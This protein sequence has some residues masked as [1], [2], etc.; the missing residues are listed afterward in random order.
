[1]K[2]HTGWFRTM[3]MGAALVLLTPGTLASADPDDNANP[4]DSATAPG[5]T[6]RVA[7]KWF[8]ELGAAPT[9]VGG[10]RRTV[11]VSQDK[12]ISD[13][14][15]E[16][17]PAQVS[18]NYTSLFNGFAVEASPEM[19]AT[20]AT[21]PGVK[22]VY[23]VVPVA[24]PE[25]QAVSPEL[26]SALAMTGADVVQSQLGFTGQGIKVGIIDTGIDYDHPDFGGSGTDGT[27]PWPTTRVAYG[28]DFVGDDYNAD[29]TSPDFDPVPKPD[30]QPDDCNGHGTHVAGIVG[31][32]GLLTGVA[33]GATLGAYRIFGC[34]GASD[35][36]VVLAAMEK[37]EAD[38]MDVVNMSLGAAY[39]SWGSYPTST[40]ADRLVRN[41]VVVVAS[42][43][44][45]GSFFTQSVGSPSAASTAISVASYDNT[46]V[47]LEE[48][49][50]R[51][52]ADEVS[53]G[54][55]QASGAP[56]PTAALDGTQIMHTTDPI[57]CTA[58]TADLT[59][60]VAITQRGTCPFAEK[61]VYAQNAG[62]KALIIYNN[63][64]GFIAPSVSGATPI[65]IPVVGIRQSDG[66]LIKQSL[67]DD[68]DIPTVAFTGNLTTLPNPTAGLISGFSSWGL[69]ADLTLK[70]DL[71][72][73]G[74]DI[75]STYPLE[76][77]GYAT[78]SGTSMAAPHVAGAVA[79]MLQANPGL[80]PARVLSNL[81]NTAEPSLYS[82]NPALGVLDGAHHQ[83]AGLIQV[84]KA[85]LGTSSVSPGKIS[86]GESADGPHTETLTL[87][88]NGIDEVTWNLGVEDAVSTHVDPAD[89][90]A[91]QSDV[92]FTFGAATV[93]F[94]AASVTIPAGGTTTV[95]VTISPDDDA[96]EG[97][98][99]SGFIQ[100]E[101]TDGE[102]ISVPFAGMAG[103]YGALP[104]LP[105]LDSGLP[106]LVVLNQCRFWEDY[107]CID[108]DADFEDAD[109]STVYQLG[110]DLPSVYAVVAY[111][112]ARLSM[113]VL[114]V[115]AAGTPIESSKKTAY[116]INGV[117]RD[118]TDSLWLWDGR[119]PTSSGLFQEVAPGNYMLRLTALAA[120]GD[121]G[122]QSW[123]SPAFGIKNS[124]V[125]SPSPT[126]TVT[127]TAPGPQPSPTVTVTLP[128]T[129]LNDLYSTPGY[130]DVNGRKWFTACEK[131]SQTTRCRTSIFGTQVTQ[132]NGK[133]VAR[134]GWVFN[135]LTYLPSPRALW[136]DNP[137]GNTGEYTINGRQWRTECDTPVSGRNGC[138]SYIRS[139]V[140]QV[141]PKGSG[142]N[143]EWKTVWVFNNIVRF[144]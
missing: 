144:S 63:A 77:D 65:T 8:V 38:G 103:D 109:A 31:A 122:T 67:T 13:A 118:E 47:R 60:K 54:F 133:F 36:A 6:N 128:P 10:S 81:Q 100:L 56:A 24:I 126:P 74:G 139:R 141:A 66:E 79:L 22:A 34:D 107:R 82:K 59:G 29:S 95:D 117:G 26:Y 44:N 102:V 130:H 69:A 111:P 11:K 25:S 52:G 57:G 2:R 84:D 87:V 119:L 3:A 1:M 112:A 43:G 89:P 105:D 80:T 75:Y 138:R 124:P 15:A 73:P 61:A 104:I 94:S 134:N 93:Q 50:V 39:E 96:V 70:P 72:A 136:K 20:Y 135:N 4:T 12:F 127:V 88:N 58:E 91:T 46:K 123:T 28:Y 125:P 32:G 78:L 17:L 86:T 55:S 9:S 97:T 113:E 64:T 27:T 14:R 85:I 110:D 7:G 40:A 137:L 132:E 68:A 30:A 83:G 18:R 131:Y 140:I 143:Y 114:Q 45:N 71:G 53:V 142:Y 116:A 121:G 19:A 5:P 92:K 106:A 16:G 48:M 41:G 115:S 62:A 21:I 42:A 35:T 98:Q 129:P 37:A 120:D 90:T 33:P 51:D 108:E 101:S 23:P 99:Y 76:E 49:L